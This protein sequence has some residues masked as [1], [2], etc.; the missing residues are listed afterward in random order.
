MTLDEL[1]NDWNG[2]PARGDRIPL[3]NDET[4]RDGLQSPSVRDPDIAAKRDLT[5]RLARL[6]V[7]A[8]D[9]GMPGAGPKALAAVRAL[10][11]EIRDH[12]LPISPNVAVRTLEADLAQVAEIQQ[13]AGMPLE[14]GAF[15]GSS[16]IRMD[17]EGWDLGFLV[18]TARKAIAFCRRQ[19]VPVMMVTEDSTRARPDVLKAIYSAALDEGAQS[20]CLSD[21]CGHATPDG[22]RRLLRFIKDEVV[23]DRSVRI[24]WHG[25]NDRGL[26]VANAIAAFEAG[27]DRLHGS[28][29]GI[30]ERCGNVAMD[31]LMINLHLMGFPKGDLSDLPALAELVA[32]LCDV[33]IPANYPVLGRDAFRTGTGVHAA[34][35]VKAL[36]R[37]DVELA[38]A[39]Y[40]G[41]P[42]ALVGRRQ[43][44]EIGPMAGHSNV[45]Y[46]LEMN[47]YDP[48]PERVDRILQTAK[49]SPRILSET[50]IRSVL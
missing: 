11:V 17:V 48:S 19:E 10:M 1:I 29:L 13:R 4:L 33:E 9:L 26:G 3:L 42:A 24:D 6:G 25:H 39:V 50:E 45:V 27:A 38:D 12:R 20:I 37:G 34:A 8:V 36:H 15:L 41:V 30:G 40:S 44:I 43:E 31:Q 2:L 18:A 14:A 46:W 16:P 21:T 35:I 32:E 22:V 47:G 5:H 28:I 23:K 49:N 7:D